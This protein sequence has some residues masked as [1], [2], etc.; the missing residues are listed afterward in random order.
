MFLLGQIM[1]ELCST[2][3]S[4]RDAEELQKR[5]SQHP[6]NTKP[7]TQHQKFLGEDEAPLIFKSQ[8]FTGKNVAGILNNQKKDRQDH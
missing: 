2:D 8:M 4:Q 6:H 1:P 3:N 7:K 5:N